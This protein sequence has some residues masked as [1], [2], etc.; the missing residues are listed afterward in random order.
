MG[1]AL[2]GHAVTAYERQCGV[3]QV[4]KS[5]SQLWEAT[6]PLVVGLCCCPQGLKLS[7]VEQYLR[8]TIFCRRITLL[9][10]VL[11]YKNEVAPSDTFCNQLAYDMFWDDLLLFFPKNPLGGIR[12]SMTI[13]SRVLIQ[14]NFVGN[15]VI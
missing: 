5:P 11:V 8:H 13:L 7:G 15:H 10:A 1:F 9:L 6:D 14:M 12:A 3:R 4:Q 2:L